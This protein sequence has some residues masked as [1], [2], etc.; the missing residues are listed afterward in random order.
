MKAWIKRNVEV[1]LATLLGLITCKILFYIKLG[2]YRFIGKVFF[3]N[4]KLYGF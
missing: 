4:Q 3:F 2:V 1:V